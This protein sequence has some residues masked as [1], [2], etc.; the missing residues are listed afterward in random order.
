MTALKAQAQAHWLSRLSACYL[1]MR[2]GSQRSRSFETDAPAP[3]SIKPPLQAEKKLVVAYGRAGGKQTGLVQ[4]SS[5]CHNGK[6]RKIGDI[7]G[8]LNR[9]PPGG[10]SIEPDSLDEIPLV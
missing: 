10:P 3:W 5:E 2:H 8:E 6:Q 7:T 1:F 9:G 4:Y